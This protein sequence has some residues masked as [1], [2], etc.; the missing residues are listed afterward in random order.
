MIEADIHQ[1]V[2]LQESGQRETGKKPKKVKISSLQQTLNKTS[3]SLISTLQTINIIQQ[4]SALI[5][6]MNKRKGVFGEYTTWPDDDDSG[7]DDDE[8]KKPVKRP[9]G[10]ENTESPTD[11]DPDVPDEDPSEDLHDQK[12]PEAEIPEGENTISDPGDPNTNATT[13]EQPV[14]NAPDP[15]QAE[16]SEGENTITDTDAT[17]EEEPVVDAPDAPEAEDSE[18]EDTITDPG[19][20]NTNATTE[21]EPIENAPG[22]SSSQAGSGAQNTGSGQGSDTCSRRGC[23]RQPAPNGVQ[24]DRCLDK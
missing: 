23:S 16:I 14:G 4:H 22:P 5:S 17:I 11:P 24:C 13:E 19:N 15:S 18:G 10:N 1:Y 20:P 3:S 7:D 8:A 12:P 6:N 9:R 2:S 21:E